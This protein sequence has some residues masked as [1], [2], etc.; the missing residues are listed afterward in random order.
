M[1]GPDEGKAPDVQQIFPPEELSKDAYIKSFEEYK[2][3]Y[4]RSINDVD[5]FWGEMAE[6]LDWFQKWDSVYSWDEAKHALTWFA[7]GKLNVSYNC[8]LYTSD[9][10]ADQ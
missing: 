3:I 5:N 8:L 6:T 4:D 2:K 9:A 10:A 7:G 1:A